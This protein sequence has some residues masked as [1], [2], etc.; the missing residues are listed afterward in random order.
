VPITGA[1]PLEEQRHGY[2]LTVTLLSRSG[3]VAADETL[4]W[5]DR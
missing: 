4:E 2:R 1:L 5:L 3:L